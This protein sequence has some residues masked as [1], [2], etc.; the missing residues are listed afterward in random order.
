MRSNVQAVS[1]L[2]HD[3]ARSIPAKSGAEELLGG[4]RGAVLNSSNFSITATDERGIIQA[5]NSGAEK[6]LGYS[7]VDTVGKITPV[8]MLDPKELSSRPVMG[9]SCSRRYLS[10]TCGPNRARSPDIFYS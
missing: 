5:F 10:P 6:M 4:L 8:E 7:A 9:V 3:C 2:A 1:V